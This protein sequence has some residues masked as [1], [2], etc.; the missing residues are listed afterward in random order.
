MVSAIDPTKPVDGVPASKAD[1]RANLQAAKDEIEALQA[2]GGG[3]G[4]PVDD[5]T[6]LVR[7]EGDNTKTAGLD[8]SAVGTGQ[9]R[10][11]KVPDKDVDLSTTAQ[12]PDQLSEINRQITMTG[13][14]VSIALA[15]HRNAVVTATS[16]DNT[17]NVPSGDEGA[18]GLHV[19]NR[20]ADSVTVA[21]FDVPNG[22]DA[23]CWVSGTDVEVQI[24]NR[25]ITETFV[26]AV[27]SLTL[28]NG[29]TSIV[30]EQE[31]LYSADDN[32]TYTIVKAY[33]RGGTAGLKYT[34]G[35][36]DDPLGSV[37]TDVTGLTGITVGTTRTETLATAA[38]TSDDGERSIR[39][40]VFNDSGGSI[41]AAPFSLVVVV[42]KA[43]SA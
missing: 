2:G 37:Y 43:P 24:T 15:T 3:A 4:V 34:V 35:I 38:N 10:R 6:A 5:G 39:L 23:I 32:G 33:A 22:S 9:F 31:A 14:T 36:A 7:D 28:G 40:T 8:A 42:E 25:I 41:T 30:R 12:D 11:I 13:S 27:G 1:L 19:R 16:G 21:G 26:H 20:G 17:L 29:A 18:Y